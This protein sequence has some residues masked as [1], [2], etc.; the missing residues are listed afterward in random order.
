MSVEETEIVR[1][2]AQVAQLQKEK[3]ANVRTPKRSAARLGRWAVASVLILLTAVLAL[4]AVPAMFLRAQILDTE[5]YISTVAPLA[6]DPAIQSEIADK[7][8]NQI[9]SAVNIEVTARDALAELTQ[10]MPRVAPVLAGLAPAM[11][12]QFESIVHTAVTNFVATPQFHDLWI[13]VNRAAHQGIVSLASGETGGIARIDENGAVTISTKEIIAR[14]KVQLVERGVGIA[15]RIPEADAS[16]TLFQS[17]ELVRA[18]QAIN[19]LDRAAPLVVGLAVVT[20]LGAIAVTPRGGRRRSTI[21]VG[22]AFAVAMALLALALAIGRNVYLNL[23]PPEAVSPAAAQS[24]ID[25]LIL[26]MRTTLRMVF[27]V[28]LLVAFVAFLGGNSR[29][30]QHLRRGVANAGDLV[31]GKLGGGHAKPWQ[32]SLARYRRILEATI[33]GVAGLV[34]IFW[35]EPTAAVAIWTAIIAGLLILLLELASRP[36]LVPEADVEPRDD[37]LPPVVVQP[38]SHSPGPPDGP[39]RGHG[40]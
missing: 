15:A 35:Q 28:G 11:A 17:P 33:L 38:G 20:A 25:T 12:T 2:K 40:K 14:V 5:R 30:A 37:R 1:L 31:S 27:V 29:A 26:P 7:V 8:T 3:E 22:I 6:A 32:R 16:I 34:L 9:T 19:T 24:L 13:Q 36:A 39:D 21:W 18:A 4:S 10:T 23:V